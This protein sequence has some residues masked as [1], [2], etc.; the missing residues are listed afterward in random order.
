M[1][2]YNFLNTAPLIVRLK[3]TQKC[4]ISKN[5]GEPHLLKAQR[6]NNLGN[7]AHSLILSDRKSLVKPS[8]INIDFGSDSLIADLK[9]K[10][11]F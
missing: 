7:I 8:F 2:K 6:V 11:V 1:K 3:F 4:K 9:R 5:L 10:D